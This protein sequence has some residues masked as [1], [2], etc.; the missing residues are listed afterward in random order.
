MGRLRSAT[1]VAVL[2]VAVLGLSGCG[3]EQADVDFTEDFLTACS[4]PLDDPRLVGDICQ[5]VF[6]R[7]QRAFGIERWQAI[8]EEMKVD[9]DAGLPDELVELLADCIIEEG[10]L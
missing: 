10:D 9:A 2:L 3:E 8:D 4:D 1:V 7:S 6:E 5:C